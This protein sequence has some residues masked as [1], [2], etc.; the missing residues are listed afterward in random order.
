MG[1]LDRLDNPLAWR[2]MADHF[3]DKINSWSAPPVVLYQQN[4]SRWGVEKEIARR[5][6]DYP[7]FGT[8]CLGKSFLSGFVRVRS[9]R[10]H[11]YGPFT[12]RIVFSRQFPRDHSAP[13]VYL[14]SHRDRWTN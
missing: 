1:V 12:I 13:C 6:L 14:M 10:N 11:E 7:K 4:P 5:F 9:R 2:E 8:D 3:C